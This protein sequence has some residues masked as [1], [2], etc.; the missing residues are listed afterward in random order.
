MFNHAETEILNQSLTN[1]KNILLEEQ[2][3]FAPNDEEYHSIEAEL[4]LL[5]TIQEKLKKQK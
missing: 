4:N 2:E 1:Y 5:A 3:C